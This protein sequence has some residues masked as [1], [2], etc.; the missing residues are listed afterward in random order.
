MFWGAETQPQGCC[1]VP[2][3]CP[4]SAPQNAALFWWNLR[5]NGD[6]DGDTL[7]AGCPVLAGD[8]WGETCGVTRGWRGTRG[9]GKRKILEK[10]EKKSPILELGGTGWDGTCLWGAWDGGSRVLCP[11]QWRTSGST[12][13]G[14]N[15]GGPAAAIPG[16]EEDV[17]GLRTQLLAWTASPPPRGGKVTSGGGY[18]GEKRG[19]SARGRMVLLP[20]EPKGVK[21]KLN[22]IGVEFGGASSV[23]DGG[24]VWHILSP[25]GPSTAP[26]TPPQPQIKTLNDLLIL[27]R[28]SPG[29]TAFLV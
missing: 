10:G 16:T 18:P 17:G 8:K 13:T 15:F 1:G 11:L 23:W 9:V 12:S 26:L 21:I 5:R 19:G 22:E 4:L 25:K 6:G 27:K 24:K 14:R 2:N 7:H 28:P 29:D 3:P 20:R